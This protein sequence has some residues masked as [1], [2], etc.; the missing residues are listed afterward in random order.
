MGA[1]TPFGSR[2]RCSAISHA[3][4]TRD[5]DSGI[6][7][8]LHRLTDPVNTEISLG[9][10]WDARDNLRAAW[11]QRIVTLRYAVEAVTIDASQGDE[12]KRLQAEEFIDR[13]WPRLPKA[14]RAVPRGPRGGPIDYSDGD[15]GDLVP[16]NR[17]HLNSR[18]TRSR[19]PRRN[20]RGSPCYVGYRA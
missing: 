1:R 6:V 17:V 16:V 14:K 5:R 15:G 13:F 10:E 4:A 18:G 2:A 12:D 9:M 8:R 7:G 11:W 3:R 19:E 20:Q